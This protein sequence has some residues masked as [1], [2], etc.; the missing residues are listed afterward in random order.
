MKA[1][2]IAGGL[3]LIAG[4][5]LAAATSQIDILENEPTLSARF[6]PYVLALILTF[7]G[8]VLMLKPGKAELAGVLNKLMEMRGIAFAVLFLL[9]ALTFRFVDFRFG[10]WLFLLS[11]MWILGARKWWELLI[12]PMLFS[13]TL[14][15]L[16]RYGFIVLLPTWM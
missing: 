9:Y 2:R 14:Y 16:F 5:A 10:T 12:L 4:L 15:L 7:S 8:I 11:T 6:F 13:G 1:D 3:T